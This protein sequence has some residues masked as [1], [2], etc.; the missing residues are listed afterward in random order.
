LMFDT[1]DSVAMIPT[2]P[3]LYKCVLESVI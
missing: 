3:G 2:S 1:D